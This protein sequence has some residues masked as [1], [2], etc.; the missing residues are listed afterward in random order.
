MTPIEYGDGHVT[1]CSIS[2]FVTAGLWPRSGYQ[3]CRVSDTKSSALAWGRPR[4]SCRDSRVVVDG[5]PPYI[6]KTF[7]RCFVNIY[8]YGLKSPARNKNLKSVRFVHIVTSILV[9]QF[10]LKENVRYP[11][12]T[13]RD[14]IFSDSRDPMIIFS[15]SKDPI[16]NSRVPKT[17]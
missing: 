1:R 5:V 7:Y 8:W 6:F 17:P 9:N 12:W 16:L 14:P 10:F 3:G 2:S 15:D 4:W 11:V 13:C